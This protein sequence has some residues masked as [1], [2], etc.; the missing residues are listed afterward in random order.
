MNYLFA[1]TNFG[2]EKLLEN[3]LLS[4]GAKNINIING[5]I[6]YESND[7]LLYKSLMW[8][9]IASRIYLCIKKFT[10]SNAKDLYNNIYNINWTEIF[11][12][13]N[14]F[15]VNFKGTNNI[16]RNSLFGALII[17]DAIVD[18]FKNKY[19]SRPNINF[20]QPDIRIKSLL[21][22]NI[23]HIMLDLS[24]ES[25]NKRGYRQFCNTTPIKENLGSAIVLS[26][27]WNQNIPMIDPMCGSGTLLIEAAMIASDRAPGLK[28]SK[29]GFQSWK[30]YNDNLWQ[31]VIKEAQE[32]F[33]IGIKK[34]FKNY[35]IGYDYD[36][37]IIKKAKI[38]ASNAGVLKI[39]QFLTQDLNNLKN[40]YKKKTEGILLT[41]PPYGERHQTE[42]QLVGL[43]IQIGKVSKKYFN[44]WKLSIFSSS[45][46]LLNFVQMQS[47]EQYFFK[48]G[49]LDCIQKNFLIF[50]KSSN[51]E[52]NEFKN[53]LN[54]NFKKL[55][56]WANLENLESFRIYNADLPNYNIIVDIY[57]K[58][59]VIQEYKAPKSIDHNQAFKRLCH[60]IYYSKEILSIPINNI[61]L[62]TRKKNKNKTQYQKLFNSSNFII[63]KEYHAKFLVNLT[64]YLDTGLFSDKRLIRKLLGKMAQGKDFLNLFSYTG[65]ASVYAGL[66]K[67]NSTTSVDISHTYIKW[68]MRNMCLNNLTSSQHHFIQADC[69]KWLKKTN[70]KF[71][72]I[73]VNPPTFSNSKKMNQVFDLKKD[74]MSIIVHLKRI[75]HHN[76]D[77]I[78][79]SS[80]RNFEINLNYI[81]KI[82][83]YAKKITKKIQSKDFLK[84][85]NVYHS[86]LIKHVK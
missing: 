19:S 6:Y 56:K 53:R 4:L 37:E 10:I 64:D 28:R 35:F 23:L 71:D 9:R 32:R 74:Y 77:I 66:G 75:L 12:I 85:P 63:I 5:G 86:W 30:Q 69:L 49:S 22:N 34:C 76:G 55:R 7:L 58:W 1:S 46:F 8:S 43:Y 13:N 72:L 31:E 20:I 33:K 38:N 24:G 57:Q 27:G 14:T 3:E 60:A 29:W 25:L 50:S 80:T 36:T 59:I 83:L 65:T 40:I 2:T 21:N 70:Q 82:Q 44:K 54:K 17:K 67:A 51:I 62:K 61:I 47:Y 11:D 81:K 79:S 78:F 48:N 45:I 84:N 15:L 68:S 73:F 41:N 16:I 26:S 18:Q 39:I 52:Q 42:S